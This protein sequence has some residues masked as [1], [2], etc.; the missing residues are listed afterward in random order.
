VRSHTGSHSTSRHVRVGL[1]SPPPVVLPP[2]LRVRVPWRTESSTVGPGGAACRSSQGGVNR[3]LLDSVA[4]DVKCLTQHSVATCLV[5]G[6]LPRPPRPCAMVGRARATGLPAVSGASGPRVPRPWRYNV[7][8]RRGGPHGEGGG[9]ARRVTCTTLASDV[10][11]RS[12]THALLH[13]LRGLRFREN[14]QLE[15][16][17]HR[18]C[19]LD[20]V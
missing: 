20:R 12:R 9:T 4:D 5:L 1:Q 3:I 8:R 14:A 16:P 18:A 6:V 7:E 2:R 13:G 11:L 15:V 17:G 10:G 19:P